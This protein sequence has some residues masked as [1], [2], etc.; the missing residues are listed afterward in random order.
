[1]FGFYS[2]PACKSRRAI[3]PKTNKEDA[4]KKTILALAILVAGGVST[5]ANAGWVRG[6]YRSNGTYVQPYYRTNPDGNL[7]NNL[8]G[9]YG[10]LELDLMKSPYNPVSFSPDQ[11]G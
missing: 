3:K 10:K 11:I 9:P 1:M 8:R 4:M 5:V 7:Y 6:H 2:D